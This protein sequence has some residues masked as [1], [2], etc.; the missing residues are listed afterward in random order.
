MTLTQSTLLSLT[1]RDVV[2]AAI[3]RLLHQLSSTVSISHDIHNVVF[4]F[5]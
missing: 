2:K 1:A 5:D 3:H 4:L